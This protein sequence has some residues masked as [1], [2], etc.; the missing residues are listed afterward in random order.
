MEDFQRVVVTGMGLITPLGIGVDATVG[1][2]ETDACGIS[3]GNA[4]DILGANYWTGHYGAVRGFEP[5]RYIDDRRSVR[6][7]T[8]NI[9]LAVSAA[10]LALEDAGWSA[11]TDE[12]EQFSSGV[13]MAMGPEENSSDFT[14]VIQASMDE[15]GHFSYKLCG[16]HGVSKCPPLYILPRLP[17]TAAGQIAILNKI[18]GINFSI[19]NNSNGGAVAIGEAY[20]AIRSGRASM[21]ITG[22]CNSPTGVLSAYR[23]NLFETSFDLSERGSVPFSVDRKGYIPAEGAAVLIL[24]SERSARARGAEI[25]AE[26]RAYSNL[27][28]PRAGADLAGEAGGYRRSIEATLRQARLSPQQIGTINANGLGLRM[29]DAAETSAIRVVFDGAHRIPPVSATKSQTG[30][31]ETASPALEFAVAALSIKRGLIP[32]TVRWHGGDL[33]CDLD[34]VTTGAR[35]QRLDHV[36]AMSY[37]LKGSLCGFV[38]SRRDGR[39]I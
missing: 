16:S 17:N 30:F 14:P 32:P 34:Y 35:E 7:T 38:L 22:G 1:A 6:K 10:R 11:A 25:Y 20:R 18:K 31:M 27:Y 8:R 19:V 29:Q 9:H 3:L 13:I 12:S 23:N 33:A 37:D 15:Q 5:E 36:L 21:I 39:G 26:V 4:R 2:I 28:N 24:E